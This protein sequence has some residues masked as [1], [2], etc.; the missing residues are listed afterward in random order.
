MSTYGN[1]VG[2]RAVLSLPIL[3]AVEIGHIPALLLNCGARL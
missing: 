3:L 1:S 2:T